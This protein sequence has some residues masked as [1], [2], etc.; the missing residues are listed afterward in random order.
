M[1]L[2]NL[3]FGRPVFLFTSVRW[4]GAAVGTSTPG[5]MQGTAFP[6][7]ADGVPTTL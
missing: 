6:V 2:I 3:I 5:L 4:R 1:S 7:A